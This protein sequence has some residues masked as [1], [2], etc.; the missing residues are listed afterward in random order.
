VVHVV[1]P[2]VGRKLGT[3]FDVARPAVSV[4]HGTRQRLPARRSLC[5]ESPRSRR[6]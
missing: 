4:Q 6:G 1:D 5:G 3:D 2:F